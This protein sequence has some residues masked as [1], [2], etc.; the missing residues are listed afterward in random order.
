M[1]SGLV[2]P[3]TIVIDK[4][5]RTVAEFTPGD[6]PGGPALSG[7]RAWPIS[8]ASAST[9]SAHSAPPVDIE[10]A[11]AIDGWY[12]LQARPITTP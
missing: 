11:F 12:L 2:T 9:S 4:A 8:S 3:D 10:A 7:R 6:Q 1:V 5:S